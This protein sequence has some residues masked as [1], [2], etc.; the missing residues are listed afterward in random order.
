MTRLRFSRRSLPIASAAVA[1]GPHVLPARVFGWD[2]SIPPSEVVRAGIAGLGGRTRWILLNEILPGVGIVA[3]ADGEL[4]RF[5]EMAAAVA[6][7]R[8]DLQPAS[9]R[10]YAEIPQMLD[11]E[12]LDA[13]FV[14]MTTHTRAWCIMHALAAGC[15]VYGAKPLSLTVEEGR[16]LSN[17]VRNLNRIVQTG[18]QQRS[19]PIN[20]H[21]SKLVRSGAN[22]KVLDVVVHDF[23]GP[24]KWQLQP[25][26]PIPKGLN[27]DP[28]ANQV[29][30]RPYHPQLRRSGS[31]WK[32]HDGGGQ[33]WGVS[34]W[35]TH[36]LDQVQC[37]LGTDDTV[38]V[39]IWLDEKDV[40]GWPRVVM[41]YASGTLPWHNFL[42]GPTAWNE[43]DYRQYLDD[44]A[45]RGLN[46]VGFHCYTGGA[47]RYAPY[48][49]PLIRIQ[50][51]VGFEFGVHPPEFASIVP[52]ES[53]IPGALLPDP[54]HPANIEIL[55]ATLQDL[56]AA[57]PELDWVW[58]WLHEHS[59]FVAEPN[60]TG[61][62]AQFC[63]R[64]KTNF[65]DAPN[66]HD[67]FTGVWSLAQIRQ[68]HE[69]LA[70]HS[71]QTRFAIG[72]R[73]GGPQPPPVLSGL[74][75][76]TAASDRVQPPE[77][78]HGRLFGRIR[79]FWFQ[80]SPYW[81]VGTTERTGM[82]RHIH[83][84]ILALVVC[85]QV[86]TGLADTA[87]HA[88]SQFV[89]LVHPCPYE[90]LGR[91]DDD[92]YRKLERA[93]CER[94]LDAI[95][96]LPASTFAVQI[97]GAASGPSPGKLHEALI[98]RLGRA[99]V[100]RVPVEFVSP[101]DPGRLRDYYRRIDQCIRQQVATKGLTFD[102]AVTKAIIWGQS[103]EGCASGYGGAVATC[104]GLTT[105]TE[106]EYRMSAPDAHIC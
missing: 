77:F 88:I 26:Q 87:T 76:R 72:G 53:R 102:L 23:A 101:E 44:L 31:D 90:A 94:W 105:A 33:S 24:A 106:F 65:S 54:T 70:K 98:N 80:R 60:L 73:G 3:V 79:S 15:D 42:S 37:A 20:A 95:P 51:A 85:G 10:K 40:K 55:Q 4:P 86:R 59:T 32:D 81:P 62:F 27:R 84:L 68:V 8:P 93:A 35:G 38:P 19:M 1:I 66:V 57:Y 41:Q 96:S 9:W 75:R 71:P 45:A 67:V 100:V 82:H 2:G 13:I 83:L 5:D 50:V 14:E 64:E 91:P 48:V 28:W 43:N 46:F 78:G 52:T 39:E 58:L 25:E 89:I 16:V 104:L 36:S 97:D 6:Q 21:C 47:E 34:G 99:R 7:E 63:D 12:K 61:R 18:T 103:F 11:Q 49:E 30:L 22:G 17:A 74:D 92:A 56:L 69:Y 29:K